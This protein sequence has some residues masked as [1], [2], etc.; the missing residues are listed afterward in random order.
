[1]RL[2]KATADKLSKIA[3]AE[4]RSVSS[5]IRRIVAD[6]V[7]AYKLPKS[8]PVARKARAAKPAAEAAP[9]PA[10]DPLASF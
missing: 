7:A 3:V 8:A 6:A 4:D 10:A 9:E 2:D 1:M 5:V